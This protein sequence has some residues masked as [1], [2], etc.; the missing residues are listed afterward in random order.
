MQQLGVSAHDGKQI[1][2]V[3]RD[4]AGKPTDCLHSLSLAQCSFGP[5]TLLHLELQASVGRLQ[6]ACSVIDHPL[7]SAGIAGTEQ[8]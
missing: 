5:L 3:V 8:Q 6:V 7:H 4:A 1:V 2:E